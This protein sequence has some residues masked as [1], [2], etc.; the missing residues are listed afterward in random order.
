MH[1]VPFLYRNFHSHHHRLYVPY[2]FGA[3]YN[4]PVEGFLLDTLG[5]TIAEAASAMTV[6]QKILLFG[7][8]SLK[9]VDDHSGYKLWWDPMQVSRIRTQIRRNRGWADVSCSSRTMQTTMT[10]IISRSASSQTSRE[11]STS[12][13]ASFLSGC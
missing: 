5:A 12:Y 11:C 13:P 9:T 10:S 6:R 8:A 3:L 4:H 7:F 2:A 1:E